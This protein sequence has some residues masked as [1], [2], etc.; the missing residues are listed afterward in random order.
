MDLLPIYIY[1][2]KLKNKPQ[3]VHVWT[4]ISE[5]LLSLRFK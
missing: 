1:V 3:Y 4:A 2:K 5:H